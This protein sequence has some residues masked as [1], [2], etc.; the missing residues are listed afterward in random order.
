MPSRTRATRPGR[1]FTLLELLTA[2]ALAAVIAAIALPAY[3]GFVNKS[4]SAQ[5]ISDIAIMIL[6]IERYHSN[7]GS[8]PESLADIGWST[9][10]PWGSPY[11]YYNIQVHGKGHARKDHALNPLNHDFDLYSMGADRKSKPQITQKDS[12]DDIIRA[13]DGGFLGLAAD[14]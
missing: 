11:E 3:T 1:G 14:F 9:L 12:L 4:R 7:A 10:D 8:Y 2:C 6:T 5:A 13:N